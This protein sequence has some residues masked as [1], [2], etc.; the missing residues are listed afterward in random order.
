MHVR[1]GPSAFIKMATKES[2][3][4]NQAA[5]AAPQFMVGVKCIAHMQ[6]RH[7]YHIRCGSDTTLLTLA[8]GRCIA[9]LTYTPL[10]SNQ[11]PLRT[12]PQRVHRNQDKKA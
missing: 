1:Q 5:T 10:V 7:I 11:T 9:C 6:A 8:T 3:L 4:H 12:R 2:I